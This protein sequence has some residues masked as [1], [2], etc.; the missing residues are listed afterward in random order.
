MWASHFIL[1]YLFLHSRLCW[2]SLRCGLFS[3]CGAPLLPAGPS[4]LAEHRPSRASAVVGTEASLLLAS[5]QASDRAHVPRIG[6]RILNHGTTRDILGSPSWW[7][8]WSWSAG[9]RAHSNTSAVAVQGL[10]N[11]GSRAPEHR[12]S[13]CGL[14]A[15]LL[16][17]MWD[18]P[19]PG[20]E[21]VS[22]VLAGRFFITKPFYRIFLN[23]LKFQPTDLPIGA[24]VCIHQVLILCLSRAGHSTRCWG[25]DSE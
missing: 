22:P 11:W 21:P 5:S 6:R 3:S 2:S 17:G 9:S 8:L 15:Q 1:F 23:R 13:S 19:A 12:L 20:T 14:R 24:Y 10:S 16:H 18:L 4:L 25:Y 7:L